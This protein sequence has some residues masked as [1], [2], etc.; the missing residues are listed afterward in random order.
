VFQGRYRPFVVEESSDCRDQVS[1]YIHLNPACIP[2]LREAEA[3]VRQRVTR[4]CPWSSYA[5]ELGE[6]LGPI[7]VSGL[8]SARQ[9]MA[10][11]LRESRT[12]RD[13]VTAIEAQIANAK[14]KSDDWP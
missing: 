13:R 14:S 5:A 6:R 11:R 8:G 4:D 9:I 3:G 2:S 10:G 7:T 1:R 12:L